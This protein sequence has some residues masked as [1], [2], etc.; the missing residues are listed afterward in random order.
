MLGWLEDYLS[1][2]TVASWP[3]YRV[4]VFARSTATVWVDPSV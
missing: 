3:F 1:N 4:T 2:I